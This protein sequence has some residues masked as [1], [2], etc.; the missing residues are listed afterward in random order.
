MV[1]TLRIFHEEQRRHAKLQEPATIKEAVGSKCLERAASSAPEEKT[2]GVMVI[3]LRI[4]HEEQRR[5]TKL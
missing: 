2:G 3:T 1:I 5:Q 4:F